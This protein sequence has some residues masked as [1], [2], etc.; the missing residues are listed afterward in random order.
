MRCSTP[1]RTGSVLLILL[2]SIIF[3]KEPDAEYLQI[4]KTYRLLPDGSLEF[5]YHHKVKLNTPFATNRLFGEDFV[6]YNPEYQQLEILNSV[7]T[8]TDQKK[9]SSPMNAF[10][11]VLPR[12][13]SDAPAYNHLREMV[14][15]HTGLEPGCVVD[16]AYKIRTD[17]DFLP[18][19]MGEVFFATYSPIQKMAV[20]VILPKDHELYYHF[21]NADMQPRISEDGAE[22]QYQWQREDI[23]AVPLEKN[24]PV[25]GSFTPRLVFSNIG[26][27]NQVSSYLRS[28]MGENLTLSINTK[29]EIDSL[30]M[31][32]M[33]RQDCLLTL[34]QYVAEQMGRIKC[35]PELTGYQARS[36]EEIFCSHN[37]TTWEKTLLLTA[38]L[39]YLKIESSPALVSKYSAYAEG[40]AA[41]LQF[42]DFVVSAVS[43]GGQKLFL[44]ATE[45]QNK[46]YH[47]KLQG[48][49][50]FLLRDSSIY[51]KKLPQLKY[52]RNVQTL[53]LDVN[54]NGND[55][56]S[57]Q[58]HLLLKGAYNNYYAYRRTT[59]ALE[60][61]VR[62]SLSPLTIGTLEMKQL[63]ET[64]SEAVFQITS[65]Q[66]QTAER[67]YY[68]WQ[69]PEWETGFNSQNMSV[70]APE[71]KTPLGLPHSFSEVYKYIIDIPEN[72]QP[73]A[74]LFGK[75]I[76]NEMG[77]VKIKIDFIDS[78]LTIRRELHIKQSKM[79]PAEYPKFRQLIVLWQDPNY[80]TLVIRKSALK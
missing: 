21:Y 5:T 9:V 29:R 12:C 59:E 66:P 13:A 63:N 16:F 7:T 10:N 22:R 45:Q 53:K 24:Q 27:W 28:Y 17:S 52:N 42:D 68:R 8:M 67:G 60:R 38:M 47:Y 51:F 79:T 54:W 3:A 57:G 2:I 58:G 18:G 64:E 1:Q 70:A 19:L 80:Y 15:T 48:R 62:Q 37:G 46:D 25:L 6:A 20:T 33:N 55:Q 77:E 44:S 4:E 69:L 41:L 75:S 78:Q 72:Y 11:E 50:L 26:D 34:Q 23:Q 32:C 71:R 74:P 35:G 65:A 73:V 31:D 14:V 61:S 40:V 36:A 39:D 76:T 43:K 30:V 56:L 49:T